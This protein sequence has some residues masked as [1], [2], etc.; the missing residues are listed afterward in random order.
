MGDYLSGDVETSWEPVR[1]ITG[2]QFTIDL[3]VAPQYGPD[4]DI[5]IEGGFDETGTHASGT[6][7]ISAAGIPCK[8]G[9]WEGV[10]GLPGTQ[11]PEGPEVTDE[12][13]E[14]SYHT[15]IY[16]IESILSGL[17]GAMDVDID[18]IFQF[19]WLWGATHYEFEL[20][21]DSSFATVLESTPADFPF[22]LPADSLDCDTT[23][24]LRARAMD[25]STPF[26]DWVSA[27]FHT[28]VAPAGTQDVPINIIFL[29]EEVLGA[30]HYEFELATDSSFTTILES[31]ATLGPDFSFYV[32]ASSLDY[33]TT[34][35][36]RVRAMADTTPLNDWVSDS[37]HTEVAP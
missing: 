3:V 25:Y 8:S 18:T 6:W 16:P 5:V 12:P 33:D 9:T 20:A 32:P 21:T 7:E 31:A 24:Y 10:A 26:S 22:Y 2:G 4:W 1:P 17:A 27:G 30:T 37:F 28:E 15:A 14:P 11:E 34:Y 35:Y 19:E 29:W 23:Y 13:E 36:W